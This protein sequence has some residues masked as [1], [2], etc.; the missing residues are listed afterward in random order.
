M[1]KNGN[2]IKSFH[3]TISPAYTSHNRPVGGTW[4]SLTKIASSN[5]KQCIY[6]IGYINISEFN[7]LLITIIVTFGAAR[8]CAVLL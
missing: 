2:I 3:V 8:F 6:I 1:I 4:A 5:S 7:S